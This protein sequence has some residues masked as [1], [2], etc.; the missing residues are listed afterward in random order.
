MKY[1]IIIFFLLLAFGSVAQDCSKEWI[2]TLPGTWK[3]GPKGSIRNVKPAD[4]VKERKVLDTIHKMISS[5]FRPVGCEISYSNVFGKHLPAAGAWVADPYHYQ[6][7]VLRYLCDNTSKSKYYTDYSTPTTVSI[8]AN[9]IFSLNNLY[10]GTLAE[11]ERG[12]LKLRNR[13]EKKDGY[14]YLGEE[15]L[16]DRADKIKEYR[17]L[18]TY[19][20]TLPFAYVS[21]KEYLLIQKKRLEKDI[22]DSPSQKD[23][24]NK[25]IANIDAYLKKP[26][27]ELH[28]PAIC[29][30]NEEQYFEKFVAENS[31]GSFF[32]V[33]PNLAYYHKKL[34]MSIP[35]F[36]T[37]VYKISH[38]DP[39]FEQN[40][41]NI[42]KAVDFA[43][44][45]NLLG[46]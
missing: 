13:P 44:L 4:L 14:Y 20:D 24:Y 9:T 1:S 42:Q 33:K 39:I 21:R 29:Q 11:D 19:N 8:A 40:M 18:I 41:S 28:Q 36:F 26:E 23:Y 5:K 12:Y 46:K 32:A 38:T 17:W 2:L 37:V 25:F 27:E 7:F 15:V 31:P 6:L 43:A 10:A 35:Q 3:A 22:Q 16:G 45:R 30:W 34:P